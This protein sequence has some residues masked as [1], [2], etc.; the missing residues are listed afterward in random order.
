MPEKIT[1]T[2]FPSSHRENMDRSYSRV[3]TSNLVKC[4]LSTWIFRYQFHAWVNENGKRDTAWTCVTLLRGHARVA[5][6]QWPLTFHSL[7]FKRLARL[8]ILSTSSAVTVVNQSGLRASMLIEE[9]LTAR[10]ITRNCFAWNVVCASGRLAA[11][12]DGWRPW[13]N[14][15]TL[16]ALNVR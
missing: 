9:N 10:R 2:V 7:V 3:W 5:L 6:A 4:T 13:A 16:L 15:G 8:S 11:E 1:E 12:S 14:L